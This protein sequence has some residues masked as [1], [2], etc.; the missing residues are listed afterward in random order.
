MR[1]TIMSGYEH[2]CYGG[3]TLMEGI[4]CEDVERLVDFQACQWESWIGG[5]CYGMVV[6][7][8]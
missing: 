4:I 1:A 5:G 2:R 8:R 7:E 3:W 6:G